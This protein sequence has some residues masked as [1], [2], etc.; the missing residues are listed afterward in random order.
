MES[1][2]ETIEL[3]RASS[4]GQI[5]IPKRIRKKLNMKSGSLFIVTERDKMIVLKKLDEQGIDRKDIKTL[6]LVEDA[7]KDLGEGRYKIYS[8]KEFFKEFSKW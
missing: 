5:V 3:T 4:K 2:Q 6:K 1:V 8:K 7:W